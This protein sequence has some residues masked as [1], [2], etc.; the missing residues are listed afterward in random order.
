MYISV[1]RPVAGLSKDTN[2][3]EKVDAILKKEPL[4]T[5][6]ARDIVFKLVSKLVDYCQEQIEI[7]EVRRRHSA[8]DRAAQASRQAQEEAAMRLKEEEIEARIRAEKDVWTAQQEEVRSF[9]SLHSQEGQA[10]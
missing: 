8:A 7:E 1:C 3:R 9:R 5:E 4:L 2:V 6:Q 10:W